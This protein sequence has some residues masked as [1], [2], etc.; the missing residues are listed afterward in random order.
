MQLTEPMIDS[1]ISPK[2]WTVEDIP[3]T[4]LSPEESFVSTEALVLGELA[5]LKEIPGAEYALGPQFKPF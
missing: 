2:D 5:I 1:L 4:Q 3:R